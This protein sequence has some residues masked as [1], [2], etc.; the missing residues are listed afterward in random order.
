MLAV[1]PDK[2]AL[3]VDLDGT[4]LATDLLHESFVAALKRAPWV[5]MQCAGWLA[6]GGR[7]RLKEELARRAHLD[8]ATLPYRSEVLE[9]IRE[10]RAAGRRIVLATASWKGLAE[11]VAAHL[12]LFDEVLATSP[13]EN[14]KAESKARR[15]VSACG[16]GHFDYIGDSRADR[17]IWRHARVAHVVGDPGVLLRGLPNAAQGQRVFDG[18]KGRRARARAILDAL[19]PHQWAKN[20]LLLIPLLAA[21]RVDDPAAV[22]A[23]FQALIAFCLAASSAYVLNDLLDLQADRAHP[24]KRRR[25]L[26]SGRLPISWGLAL[27]IACLAGAVAFAASLPRA[28][29]AALAVY[30]VL[31]IAYSMALKRVVIV[32]VLSLA[33]LYTLRLIAGGLAVA[34]PLSFWLLAFAVF[35]FFSLALL[36]RYTEL[37]GIAGADGS[38][39]PG[40]GYAGRDIDVVLAMGVASGLIGALVLALYMNGDT[41]T[42]L[43]RTPD[44]LW[45]LCPLY[46]YWIA[47]MWLLGARAQMDDDPV[48]FAVRDVP[49]YFV[50]AL[51]GAVVWTAT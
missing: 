35:L 25:A 2:P 19:R 47:R 23:A 30:V 37:A 5:V 10:E 36:K 17:A 20:L 24:R 7:P 32:D 4:L 34:V 29:G 44:V 11:D 14:L 27:C 41:V 50:L 18:G 46:L 22:S 31:T 33:A 26:A 45:L 6:A 15:L 49:T 43:Y 1:S 40:R 42:K 38:P 8:V 16:P 3:C 21:H 13:G 9:F 39:V 28:F 12:Q 48:L 51:G